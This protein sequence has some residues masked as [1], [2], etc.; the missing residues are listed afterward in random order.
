M[1]DAST[2]LS[3]LLI[4]ALIFGMRHGLDADHLAAIDGLARVQASQHRPA[5]ARRIGFLFS[6]GH[7]LVLLVV[8]LV[9][10]VLGAP[11]LPAWFEALGAWISFV[12]LM[13]VAA[14]NL[15]QALSPAG[16][17]PASRPG[18]RRLLLR[19]MPLGTLGSIL[20]GALFALSFDALSLAIWFFWAG[21]SHGSVAITLLLVGAFA[22]GMSITDAANGWFVSGLIGRSE[23]FVE[24]A[25]RL[26]ALLLSLMGFGV[27]LLGL[28]R[29]RVDM[30]DE[31]MG[32]NGLWAGSAVV[33]LSLFAYALAASRSASESHAASQ[34]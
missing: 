10:H 1:P 6:T 2:T 13:A 27:A 22:L 15:Q 32:S 30:V 12:F 18:L 17:A 14:A 24:R 9:C 29:M 26:F 11:P 7:G 4:F 34:K 16:A 23:R 19:I 5:A 3:T 20:V 28:A 33:A 25:R 21:T 31:W 8:A